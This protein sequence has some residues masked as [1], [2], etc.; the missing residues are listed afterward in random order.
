MSE[1][2]GSLGIAIDQDDGSLAQRWDRETAKGKAIASRNWQVDGLPRAWDWQ[3]V[4]KLFGMTGYTELC[5]G[6][7]FREGATC[8][9]TFWAVQPSGT[10]DCME[11]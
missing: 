9:W 11:I 10:E 8:T 3:A 1:S 5:V 6:A 7:S 2:A 4:H